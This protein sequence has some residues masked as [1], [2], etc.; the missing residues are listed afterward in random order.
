[1]I[2]LSLLSLL[3]LLAGDR[4][5]WAR[6]Q[7]DRTRSPLRWRRPSGCRGGSRGLFRVTTR[8]VELGG[9]TLP[10]GSLLHAG[11]RRAAG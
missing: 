8:E 5:N 7:A 9:I 10:P 3:S 6:V 2:V 4:V 1:V 11:R